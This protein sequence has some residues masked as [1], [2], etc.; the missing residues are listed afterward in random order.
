[1]KKNLEILLIITSIL[2]LLFCFFLFP[3]T[4]MDSVTFSVSIWKDNLFP[5]L[6]PFLIISFLFT[7]YGISYLVSEILKPI[8]KNLFHLP[9][10]CGFIIVLSI[11]SGFPSNA[12]FIYDAKKKGEIDDEMVNHLLSFCFYPNP[13]FVI[14]TVGTLFLGSAKLGGIIFI[15]HLLA[16]FVIAIL[17]RPKEKKSH[18]NFQL[19]RTF[20]QIKKKVNQ[21]PSFAVVLKEACLESLNTMFL[22]LGIITFFLVFINLILQFIPIDEF[23][24]T[25]LRG[26]LEMTQG[27]KSVSSLKVS[28]PLRMLLSS[29]IIAFGGI[30]IHTQIFSILEGCKTSYQKFFLYRILHVLFAVITTLLLI[31]IFGD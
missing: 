5:S 26:C 19:R 25:L 4:V 21:S 12:K 1:M 31:T 17:N 2:S 11:L 30:C 10:S 23:S 20:Q 24:S 7:N 6:F 28:L 27:L 29:S 13:L 18:E 14:G 9:S 3:K 16:S 22:L 15:S 8:T